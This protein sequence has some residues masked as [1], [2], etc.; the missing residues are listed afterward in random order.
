MKKRHHEKDM[1]EDHVE[2]YAGQHVEEEK[3]EE[4]ERLAEQYNNNN[5]IALDVSKFNKS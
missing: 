3:A 2:S 1:N 5:T 4:A